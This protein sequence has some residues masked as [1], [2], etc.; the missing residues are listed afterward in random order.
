MV[1]IGTFILIIASSVF[2]F[3]IIRKFES[4]EKTELMS[5]LLLFFWG[6][7]LLGIYVARPAS[8]VELVSFLR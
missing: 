4:F 5:Y 7:F 8:S 2:S 6:A 3:L 1:V